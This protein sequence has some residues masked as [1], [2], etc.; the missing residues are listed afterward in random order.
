MSF[1][2]IVEYETDHADEIDARMREGLESGPAMSFVRL[3]HTR[4]RGNPHR[5][6]TIVEFP[7][8]DAAMAN[9]TR[10][11]TDQMAK[12][13]ASLCTS[14]PRFYDLDVLMTMP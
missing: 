4:D 9:S 11:E 1:V 2:Q 7:S 12:E 13:L 14:G 6:V 5:Y 10:P 8:Y 3:T